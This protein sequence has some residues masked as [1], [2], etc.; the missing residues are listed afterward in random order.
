M[1]LIKCIIYIFCLFAVCGCVEKNESQD[2]STG[3]SISTQTEST[4][5]TRPEQSEPVVK[6]YSTGLIPRWQM[7]YL[8]QGVFTGMSLQDCI[9]LYGSQCV[10]ETPRN[11]YAVLET[12]TGETF[13]L[14]FNDKDYSVGLFE[15]A[16]FPTNAEFLD[17]I[18]GNHMSLKDMEKQEL[19]TMGLTGNQPMTIAYYTQEGIFVL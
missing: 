9:S 4:K 14:P 19:F 18:L 1:T 17:L 11:H 10:R 5:Q 2:N 3:T 8:Q 12:E 15:V 7:E 6:T 16:P 13:L